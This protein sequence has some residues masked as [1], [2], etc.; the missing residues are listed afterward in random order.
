[1]PGKQIE[2]IIFSLLLTITAII[3]QH[4]TINAMGVNPVVM[5]MTSAGR[6]SKGSIRV[7]N[8]G[9]NKLPVE[10]VISRVELGPE[11]EQSLRPAGEEFLI[12]PPQALVPPGATQNFRV[13]WVGKPDIPESQSYIF[14]V[15]QVP[16]KMPKGQSGV[17]LVFNFG[18][19]VNVGPPSGAPSIKLLKSEI[20][21]DK[22][23]KRRPAVTLRNSSNVHARLSDATV[24]LSGNGWSETMTPAI[25][26]QKLGVGLIQPGK[27]RKL[28]L[29]VEVPA[30]VTSIK[31]EIQY[32]P[33]KNR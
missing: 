24:R 25:L 22:R 13:Q 12:F 21:K 31:T 20:S 32:K 28:M 23:G 4:S 27:V 8:D 15:N 19:V 3:S 18:T 26:R 17:Q 33:K 6:G 10:I 14:S 7:V 5:E 29:P 11:G 1:M 30:S 9:K 2:R 16:V